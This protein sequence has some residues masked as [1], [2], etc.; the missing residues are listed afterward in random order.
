MVIWIDPIDGTKGLTQGHVD[1]LTCLIGVS[2][3]GCPRIGI[4]HKPY[5]NQDQGRTYF[6]ALDCGVFTKDVGN[7][8]ITPLEYKNFANQ[9]DYKI[10][11][12]GS[13]NKNQQSMNEIIRA[14]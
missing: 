2:I 4:V 14:L 10:C 9:G 12:V 11:V 6:G 13:M 8:Y 1:H 3:N 5:Y 7:S